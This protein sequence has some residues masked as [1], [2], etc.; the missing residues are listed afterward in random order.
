MWCI[1]SEGKGK[2]GEHV[3][4]DTSWERGSEYKGKGQVVH[5]VFMLD[6]RVL[7][8]EKRV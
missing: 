3:K 4:P 2:G 7:R 5:E 1:R 6:I 8:V